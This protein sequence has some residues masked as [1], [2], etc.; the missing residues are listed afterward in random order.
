[1]RL[2]EKKFTIVTPVY[3]C[4]RDLKGAEFGLCAARLKVFSLKLPKKVINTGE[5]ELK[6]NRKG[7]C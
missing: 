4:N 5:S 1:M 2:A 7:E 3:R 6:G